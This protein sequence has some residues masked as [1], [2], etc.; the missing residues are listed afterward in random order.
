VKAALDAW[1]ADVKKA[2]WKQPADIKLQ[3]RSASILRGRRVVF[4]VCG[5]RYRL[6]VK[7]NYATGV[8]Y[9]RFVGSHTAYDA[10]D[11]EEV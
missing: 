9:I 6:V 3:Y 7:A 4:N 2:T 5:N 10:I 8:V 11:A 1:Y